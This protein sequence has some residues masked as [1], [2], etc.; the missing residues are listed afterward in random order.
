MDPLIYFDQ[1]D[2]MEKQLREEM[3]PATKRRMEETLSHLHR[4]VRKATRHR[5]PWYGLKSNL[6]LLVVLFFVVVLFCVLLEWFW[7][8]KIAAT[9]FAV[10]IA[11][12][13]IGTVTVFL[14]MK[15]VPPD[16]YAAVL[17]TGI[18]VLPWV[19]ARGEEGSSEARELEA[20]AGKVLEGKTGRSLPTLRAE[21]ETEDDKDDI[22]N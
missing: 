19:S 10:G 4:E 22:Q 16:V 7:G 20:G 14:A 15:L 21:A 11:L 3:D 5:Q 6:I 18:S 8:W 2:R 13:V 12:L 9:A 17:R 1:I